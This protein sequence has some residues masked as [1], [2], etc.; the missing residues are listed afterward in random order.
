LIVFDDAR[1]PGTS[2]Q[3][4]VAA[5]CRT[6]FVSWMARRPSSKVGM[7]SGASPRLLAPHSSRRFLE[8][9]V[10]AGRATPSARYCSGLWT[11]LT[12]N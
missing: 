12:S 2:T 8:P 11:Q 5:D 1:Q 9:Q 6:A 7:P 10:K 4:H 3:L